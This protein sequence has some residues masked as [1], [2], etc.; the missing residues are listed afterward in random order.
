MESK[1]ELDGVG[2]QVETLEGDAVEKSLKLVNAIA[3]G[4][5]R[6]CGCGR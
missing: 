6:L 3:L 2:K 4:G 1:V 5:R